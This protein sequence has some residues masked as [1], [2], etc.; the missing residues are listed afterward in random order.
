M[1][2]RPYGVA[3]L[4]SY[5]ILDV[6]FKNN[7]RVVVLLCATDWTLVI[8]FKPG[9]DTLGVKCMCTRETFCCVRVETWDWLK[10]DCTCL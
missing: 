4:D 10:T 1:F 2:E 9:H 7:Q 3:V 8:R 6:M 5:V